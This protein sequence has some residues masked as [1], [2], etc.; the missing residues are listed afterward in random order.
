MLCMVSYHLGNVMTMLLVNNSIKIYDVNDFSDAARRAKKDWPVVRDTYCTMQVPQ[1]LTV[2][3]IDMQTSVVFDFNS[4]EM[5]GMT[6][7]ENQNDD[8]LCAQGQ[9]SGTA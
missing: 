5:I 4:L 6:K 2:S 3:T 7:A 9:F 8:T 1:K